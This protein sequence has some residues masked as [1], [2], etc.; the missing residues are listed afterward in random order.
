MAEDISKE[1]IKLMKEIKSDFDLAKGNNLIDDLEFDS[2]DVISLL[3]EIEKAF[4]I[5][6]PEEDI[7]EFDLLFID[8][9][10]EYIKHKTLAQ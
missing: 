9:F 8:K 7:A 2:L 5:A 3:F 6:I 1:L 10:E 4:N